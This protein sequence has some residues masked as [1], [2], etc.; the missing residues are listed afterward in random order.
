MKPKYV[1]LI[2]DSTC[3]GDPPFEDKPGYGRYVREML[4]GQA[5]V[6]YPDEN[7][8]FAQYTLRYL[9][10]WAAKVDKQAVDVVHWNNG[11]WDVL[12][13][14]GDEP[15]TPLD[16]YVDMLR[17][18]YQRIRLLFPNTKVIFALSGAV[19]EAVCTANFSRSNAVVDRYNDAARKLMDE[20]GVPVNDLHAVSLTFDE[21]HFSS[22]HAHKNEKG[23]R[24]YASAVIKAI[25]AL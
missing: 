14:Y 23:S 21:S 20:L 12:Q 3:Y 8:R 25:E 24:I 5:E 11:L 22:D 17:R 7:C 1:F 10:E 13:L 2:G 4:Q 18:V 16:M 9:H 6:H 19:N 15:L